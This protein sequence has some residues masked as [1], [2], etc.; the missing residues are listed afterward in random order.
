MHAYLPQGISINCNGI[1]LEKTPSFWHSSYMIIIIS[2]KADLKDVKSSESKTALSYGLE[3]SPGVWWAIQR[4]GDQ[5]EEWD[6]MIGLSIDSIPASQLPV[7][8]RMLLR[9]NALRIANPSSDVSIFAR[10]L[11]I[12]IEPICHKACVL[13]RE[14]KC[15]RSVVSNVIKS[16]KMP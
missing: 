13:T 11:S 12:E 14:F 9:Y 7:V 3:V 5:A 4:T 2:G 15:C 1:C 16:F 10:Q 8:I 6:E